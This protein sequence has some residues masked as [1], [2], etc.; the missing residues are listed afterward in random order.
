MDDGKNVNNDVINAPQNSGGIS[1]PGLEYQCGS[2]A[3]WFYWIAALSLINSIIFISG[4]NINFIAGLGITQLIDGISSQ[5]GPM[6][7]YIALGFN[8]MIAGVFALFGFL[9]NKKFSWA[10]I[11]GIIFYIIDGLLFLLVLDILAI[12]FHAFVLYYI[13][14]GFFAVR[15]LNQLNQSHPLI[16]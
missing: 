16:N 6:A 8:I 3:N 9:A 4:G 11:I 2:G 12:A 13:F 5:F 10:F 15:K 14:K 7:K 1:N